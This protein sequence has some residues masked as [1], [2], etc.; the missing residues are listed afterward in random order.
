MREFWA[1]LLTRLSKAAVVNRPLRLLT[2]IIGGVVIAYAI[3]F[4]LEK[5]SIYLFA[6]SYVDGIAEAWDLNKNLA[7]AIVWLIFAATFVVFGF[8]FSFSRRKRLIGIVAILHFA[9]WAI[10]ACLAGDYWCVF[11]PVWSSSKVLRDH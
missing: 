3:F 5:I 9:H 8:A 11:R 10:A 4:I 2:F 7:N 1:S 6:T